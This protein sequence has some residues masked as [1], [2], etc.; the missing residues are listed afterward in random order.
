MVVASDSPP[1]LEEMLDPPVVRRGRRPQKAPTKVP[2]TIRLD[3]DVF[4]FFPAQGRGYQ[5]CINEALCRV[6]ERSQTIRPQ[7]RTC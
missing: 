5:S 7:G 2:T 4:T 6:K 1:W 3:A